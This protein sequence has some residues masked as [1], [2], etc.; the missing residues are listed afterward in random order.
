MYI[1]EFCDV[2]Y[3]ENHNV[4]FVKWKKFCC[5]EDYRKPLEYA[6]EIIDKYKCPCGKGLIVTEQ[7]TH[8]GHKQRFT[9]IECKV[10]SQKYKIQNETSY[11]W[12]LVP[13]E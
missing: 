10:C 4:V 6:L 5:R 2:K 7:D 13:L 9:T 8:V 3:E 1:S 12:S 11:N